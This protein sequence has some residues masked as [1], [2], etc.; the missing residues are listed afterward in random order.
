MALCQS[1]QQNMLY[2]MKVSGLTVQ[3]IFRPMEFP[4]LKFYTVKLRWSIIINH[5]IYGPGR[6]KT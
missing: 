1:T 2:R 3:T 6:E 5:V 4:Y